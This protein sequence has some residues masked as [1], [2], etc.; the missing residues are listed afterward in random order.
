MNL[1][2]EILYMS[3]F[4]EKIGDSKFVRD[5]WDLAGNEAC[6]ILGDAVF[7]IEMCGIHSAGNL[8][9]FYFFGIW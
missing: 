9:I 8:A 1:Y 5:V 3:W 7:H 4:F 2:T 6:V